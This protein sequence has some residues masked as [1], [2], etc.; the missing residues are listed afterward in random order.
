MNGAVQKWNDLPRQFQKNIDD[1][2]PLNG[3]AAGSTPAMSDDEMAD[4]E[5][6][7]N[8]LTDGYRPPPRFDL[9]WLSNRGGR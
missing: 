6:F 7:L 1:Q 4:L 5:A 2:V 9:L 8:T 3:R